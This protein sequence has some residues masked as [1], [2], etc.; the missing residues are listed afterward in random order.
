VQLGERRYKQWLTRNNITS[1]HSSVEHNK[2]RNNKSS[3]E[4][5]VKERTTLSV[6]LGFFLKSGVVLKNTRFGF[7]CVCACVEGLDV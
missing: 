2:Q 4:G 7:V 1:K 6:H 3:Q 5:R